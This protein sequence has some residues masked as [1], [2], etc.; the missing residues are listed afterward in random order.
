MYRPT[1]AF[2]WRL[3]QTMIGGR[4]DVVTSRLRRH[5]VL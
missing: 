4:D 3:R 1:V 2:R 5:T